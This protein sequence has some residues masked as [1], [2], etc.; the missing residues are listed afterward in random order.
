MF[1]KAEVLAALAQPDTFIVVLGGL[2]ADVDTMKELAAGSGVY[3][4]TREFS[5]L[6]QSVEPFCDSLSQ[7]TELRIPLTAGAPLPSKLTLTHAALT[8]ELDVAAE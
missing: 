7:L 1:D 2:L 8:L 5:A 4:Y 3:F 6:A